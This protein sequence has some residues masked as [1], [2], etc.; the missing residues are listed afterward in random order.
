M[1]KYTTVTNYPNKEN[2]LK[3]EMWKESRGERTLKSGFP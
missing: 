3:R 2:Y 1:K